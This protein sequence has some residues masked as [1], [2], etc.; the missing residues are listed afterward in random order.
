MCDV[1]VQIII[2]IQS[3]DINIINPDLVVGAYESQAVFVLRLVVTT[4]MYLICC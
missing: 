3:Y 2:I 4:Y 1:H